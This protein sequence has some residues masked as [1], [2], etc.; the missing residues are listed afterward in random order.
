MI[1]SIEDPNQVIGSYVISAG[2]I[3]VVVGPISKDY[4]QMAKMKYLG[5]TTV[6][7]SLTEKELSEISQ[8]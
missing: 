8:L 7:E 1:S 2:D 3:S 4:G 6:T 5:Y